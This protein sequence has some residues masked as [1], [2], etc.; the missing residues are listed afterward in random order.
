MRTVIVDADVLVYQAANSAQRAIEWAPEVWTTHGD[1]GKAMQIVDEKFAVICRSLKADRLVLALSDYTDPWRRSVFPGIKANRSGVR[2]VLF[3]PVRAYM[4]DRYEVFQRPGLEGDDVLGILG[5]HPTLL[6]GQK[7]IVTIDKDL[8]GV[9]GFLANLSDLDGSP[10]DDVLQEIS[11]TDAD[12]F[13]MLQ[14]LAGDPTDGYAGCPKY[15]MVKAEKL[16]APLKT[17]AGFDVA[18]A[19]ELI[20]GCY[21]KAGLSEDVALVNARVARICRHR[22]YDFNAKRVILWTPPRGES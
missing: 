2:P 12:Y 16:L 14:A 22:D 18:A 21:V 19:W 9:P 11:E 20:V 8:K 5:T 10:T 1:L 15:G 13:H 6:P 4:H 17:D 7:I 3:E